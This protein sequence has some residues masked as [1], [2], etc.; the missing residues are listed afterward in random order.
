M[1]SHAGDEASLN[2]MGPTKLDSL[3]NAENRLISLRSEIRDLDR[4]IREF[5]DGMG[6][7]SRSGGEVRARPPQSV[8]RIDAPVMGT[9]A[10]AGT[11]EE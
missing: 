8:A 7:R 6:V 3:R 1:E 9:A 2:H 11:N 4:R 5:A 10:E